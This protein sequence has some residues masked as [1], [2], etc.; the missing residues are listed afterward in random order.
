MV[1][2]GWYIYHESWRAT[3]IMIGWV[4]DIYHDSWR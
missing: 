2:M 1:M 4:L 3:M